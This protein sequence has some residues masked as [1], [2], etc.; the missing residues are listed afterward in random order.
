MYSARLSPHFCAKDVGT[1]LNQCINV[2]I[3]QS[4]VEGNSGNYY[5]YIY[6]N[7]YYYI[8][9]KLLI[10]TYIQTG[11]QT[12]RHTYIYIYL[13]SQGRSNCPRGCARC[14]FE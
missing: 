13:L 4:G 5:Y 14:L 6:C 12:D 3:H 7:Y 10:Y 11:R 9:V 8:N 1:S 2:S